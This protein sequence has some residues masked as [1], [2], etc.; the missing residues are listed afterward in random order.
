M[1]LAI[2]RIILVVFVFE[3]CDHPGALATGVL[4]HFNKHREHFHEFRARLFFPLKSERFSVGAP[5]IVP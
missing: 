4:F 5:D 2:G 3:Y 1:R